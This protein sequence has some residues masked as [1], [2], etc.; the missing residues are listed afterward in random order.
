MAISIN[1]LHPLFAARAS[2]IDLSRPIDATDFKAIKA[3][4]DQYGVL[5]LQGPRLTPEEQIGFAGRFGTLEPQNGVLTTGI[6]SRVTRKRVDISNLDENNAVLSQADRRRMFALGNQLW[7]TDSSFKQTSASYSLL[8][9]H[10]VPPEGGETQLVDMRVAWETVPAKL[11]ARIQDLSAEH[12]IFCQCRCEFPAVRVF[13]GGGPP[14]SEPGLRA[15]REGDKIYE[16]DGT[17]ASRSAAISDR[18]AAHSIHRLTKVPVSYRPSSRPGG[19]RPAREE[20]LATK[21]GFAVDSPLEGDGFEPSV[22]LRNPR[23][24]GRL[25]RHARSAIG[26]R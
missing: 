21:V 8:H 9:A 22:P 7:H 17:A 12:S 23:A 1:S 20:A 13:G 14:R 4:V 15:P 19:R 5:L 3:A 26:T 16:R 10:D 25:S 2:G 11:Q 24:D 6:G 18:I